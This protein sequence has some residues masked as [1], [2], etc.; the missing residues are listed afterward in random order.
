MEQALKSKQTEI[1]LQGIYKNVKAASSFILDL[2]PHVKDERLKSDMTVQL[3]AYEGFAAR[4]AKHLAD[5]G[6]KPEAEGSL[7]RISAKWTAKMEALRDAKTEHI[8]EMMVEHATAGVN[9]ILRSLREAE[10]TVVSESALRIARDLCRFEEKNVED[11]K[12]Y[13]R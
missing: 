5:E 3:S 9:E 7:A 13:L 2:M 11:M 12:K 10:N 4:T 8:A 6:V 1:L